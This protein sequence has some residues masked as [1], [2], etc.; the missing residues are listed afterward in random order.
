MKTSADSDGNILEMI[1]D[2]VFVLTVTMVE[3]L[4][5]GNSVAIADSSIPTSWEL[6]RIVEIIKSKD[7]G[8]RQAVVKTPRDTYKRATSNQAVLIENGLRDKDVSSAAHDVTN[9]L[10]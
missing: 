1:P 3:P 7:G 4:G 2:W 9:S 5:E 6:G 8:V 10:E